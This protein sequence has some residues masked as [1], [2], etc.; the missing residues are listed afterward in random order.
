MYILMMFDAFFDQNFFDAGLNYVGGSCRP[1]DL[2]DMKREKKIIKGSKE[3]KNREIGLKE[4]MMRQGH[5]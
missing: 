4:R 2:K 3:E 5:F 1:W